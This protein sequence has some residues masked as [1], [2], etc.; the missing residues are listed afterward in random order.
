MT[1]IRN[2]TIEAGTT[3]ERVLRFYTDKART[4]PMDLTGYTIAAQIRAGS[5]S[6]PFAFDM[7]DAATGV[8]RMT[9]EPEATSEVQ[10]GDYA[11]DLLARAPVTGRTAKYSKGMVTIAPTQ[12]V[13]PDDE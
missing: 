7:T 8:V 1:P 11:W 6:I 4:H 2:L 3:Y 13:L 10:P 5:L 12:T 9:L